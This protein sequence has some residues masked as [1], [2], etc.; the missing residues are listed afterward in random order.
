[1]TKLI[2]DQKKCIRCGTCAAV[3]PDYF[4]SDNGRFK[5]KE[6]DVDKQMVEDIVG[7]CPLGAISVVKD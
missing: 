1:M 6:V 4:E 3:Y 2:I 7:I 5:A